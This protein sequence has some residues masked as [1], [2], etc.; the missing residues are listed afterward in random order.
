[1]NSLANRFEKCVISDPLP[2]LLFIDGYNSLSK[3]YD[4]KENQPPN[5]WDFLSPYKNIQIFVES[6]NKSG[7]QLKVFLKA[8]NIA[9]KEKDT[10][11]TRREQEVKSGRKY[12]PPK[13]GYLLLAFFN[14]CGVDVVFSYE[15]H[16]VETMA[17]YANQE[18][19][20]ILSR[21]KTFPNLKIEIFKF[22]RIL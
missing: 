15:A 21:D 17:A 4:L 20:A 10:W 22:M 7:I 9:E 12:P 2:K 8:D 3:F 6:A 18:E 16:C 14:K 19:A 5:H 1:M 13:A 11:M